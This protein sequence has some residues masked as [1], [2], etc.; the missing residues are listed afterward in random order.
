VPTDTSVTVVPETVHTPE[1]V[2]AK[3]TGRPDDAVALRVKGALPAARFGRLAK[4]MVWLPCVTWKLW[5]TGVAARYAISPGCEAC[6]VQVPTLTSVTIEPDTVQT[7]EVVDAKTTASPEDAVAVSV[8]AGIPK[9]LLGIL[10]KA[11]VWAAPA[12]VTEREVLAE[13]P[14]AES[15]L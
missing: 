15:P 5:F 11:I 6:T 10:P 14:L 9:A 12:M 1:L 7:D 13:D 8:N 3:L 2:D 4:V